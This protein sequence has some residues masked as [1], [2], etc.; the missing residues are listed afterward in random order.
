MPEIHNFVF[1]IRVVLRIWLI[2]KILAAFAARG[3]C[4]TVAGGAAGDT[5]AT[6]HD[7]LYFHGKR[8]DVRRYILLGLTVENLFH[9]R[10]CLKLFVK[11]EFYSSIIPLAP[12]RRSGAP[13]V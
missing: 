2:F 12:R 4:V 3:R 6:V 7:G 1:I 9:F 5:A 8:F 10:K 11:V 13:C